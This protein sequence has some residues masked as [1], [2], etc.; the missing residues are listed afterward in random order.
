M[1]FQRRPVGLCHVGRQHHHAC[2]P[3]RQGGLL[4]PSCL[5]LLNPSQNDCVDTEVL[6]GTR[7]CFTTATL[8]VSTSNNDEY[9]VG[10]QID[11]FVYNTLA[12]W[13]NEVPSVDYRLKF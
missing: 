2:H 8:Q 3:H 13:Y 11:T 5:P 9:N 6:M 1:H 10:T 12:Q 4:F 7:Q